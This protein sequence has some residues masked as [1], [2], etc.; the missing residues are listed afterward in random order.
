MSKRTNADDGCELM[1]NLLVNHEYSKWTVTGKS[2]VL[3]NGR[4]VQIEVAY[5]ALVFQNALLLPHVKCSNMISFLWI[6]CCSSSFYL[7]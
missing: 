1:D 4:G 2:L 7:L 3:I 6:V 5:K